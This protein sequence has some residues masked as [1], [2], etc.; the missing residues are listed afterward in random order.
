M[1]VSTEVV[2]AAFSLFGTLA[3]TF[4]GIMASNKLTNYRLDELKKQVEK[5]NSLIDRM[6]RVEMRVTVI[7]DA[8]QAAHAKG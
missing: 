8:L 4:G 6:Y 7:E 2:V 1:T 3:G 5:H